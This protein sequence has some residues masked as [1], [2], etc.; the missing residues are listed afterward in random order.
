M[1]RRAWCDQLNNSYIDGSSGH[2]NTNLDEIIL[3]RSYLITMSNTYYIDINLTFT[4][5]LLI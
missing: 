2:V 1:A 4:L 3:D 5:L